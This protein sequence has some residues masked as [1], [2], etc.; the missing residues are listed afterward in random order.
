[1]LSLLLLLSA[2]QDTLRP[3]DIIKVEIMGQQGFAETG[4]VD[5]SG[6][7]YFRLTGKLRA[8]GLSLDEFKDTLRLYLSPY[9]KDPILLVSIENLPP[10]AVMVTGRVQSPGA[11]QF[12]KGMTLS[13]AVQA[14][15]GPGPD[16]RLS[17]VLVRTKVRDR[18][19]TRSVDLGAILSGKRADEPVYPGQVIIVPKA[20][21][22]CTMENFNFL[23]SLLSTGM[24]IFTI[25]ILLTK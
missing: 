15:G 20:Y 24:T 10:P 22:L 3:G 11:V 6:F 25:Y 9:Y 7:V 8:G 23:L 17:G 19:E 12:K 14:A 5:D 13:E 2:P 21:R 4:A 18:W 1:V 16:A